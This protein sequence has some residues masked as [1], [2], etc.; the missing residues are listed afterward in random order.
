M[1]LLEVGLVQAK[2]NS[3]STAEY[4]VSYRLLHGFIFLLLSLLALYFF[5]HSPFFAIKKI[6]VA[7]SQAIHQEEVVQLASIALGTNIFRVNIEEINRRLA[8]H[9]MI[10]QAVVT[11]HIPSTLMVKIV[12][13]KPL[14]LLPVTGGFIVID[15]QGIYLT[16][17][18][19]IV[20]LNLPIITGVQLP[21]NLFP[22]RVI[23]APQL[24]AVLPLLQ[25]LDALLGQAISEV[26][27]AT[28]EKM[29]LYTLDGVEVR[30]GTVE[31]TLAHLDLLKEVLT[32]KRPDGQ[33]IE[34]IDMSFAG[35]PV[36]KY[37]Q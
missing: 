15:G 22:G 25:Q 37:R 19:S 31:Q 6:E 2:L 10:E 11:R 30:V 27:V 24:S 34:Y 18:G 36:V 21:A 29:R 28:P 17:I 8:L 35:N 1:T 3:R 5:L 33:K 16:K 4:S 23:A 20:E 32:K 7:G 13:R 9:P 12:E 26:N 14:G